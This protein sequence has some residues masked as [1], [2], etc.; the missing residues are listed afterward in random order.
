[1]SDPRRFGLVRGR[2]LAAIDKLLR[3]PT[4]EMLEALG[5]A[6]PNLADLSEDHN[7][8]KPGVERDHIL[9]DM[10]GDEW[11]PDH[12]N[13]QEYFIAAYRKALALSLDETS[14]EMKTART[15]RPIRTL[16]FRCAD[17]FGASIVETEHEITVY[18]MTPRP[19]E[20]DIPNA[21]PDVD[22]EMEPIWTVSPRDEVT[23]VAGEFEDAGFAGQPEPEVHAN[24]PGVSVFQ[25]INY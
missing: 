17:H 4:Q 5:T 25:L 11:F 7:V 8:T 23:K 9:N 6:A 2:T 20:M 13:K 10:F 14:G 12:D 21:D 19:E 15:R 18:W 22:V 3:D 16:W 1:M 24:T